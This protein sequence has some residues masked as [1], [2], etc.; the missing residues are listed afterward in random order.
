MGF[1]DDELNEV[2]K[3]CENVVLG[4]RL[5]SCVRSMVRVEIRR[6]RVKSLVVCLQFPEEYPTKTILLELKSKTFSDN[7]LKKITSACEVELKK[8]QGKP[9]ILNVLKFIR[10]FIDE[11]PLICCYDEINKIKKCLT[12]TD[13]LKLKQKSSSLRLKLKEGLYYINSSFDIP[14]NYPEKS[15]QCSI[16]TNFPSILGRFLVG[17]TKEVARRCVE[18]PLI[19]P[20]NTTFTPSPS[21]FPV[22]E[23]QLRAAREFPKSVCL[24]CNKQA[25]PDNPENS[26]TDETDEKHVERIYCG[27]LYHQK[28][29]IDYMKTPPFKGGKKCLGCKERIYHD[30]WKVGE[31]LAEDRWAHHEARMR[32]LDEV[33]DFFK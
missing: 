7:L 10:S 31:K 26:V 28:C 27:H 33:S 21:L 29:L 22:V 24:L 30:K 5:V 11:N 4:S 9:Q 8:W 20:K 19:C 32:E 12:A 25:L 18:P 3:L 16:D 15:V 23:V 14:D 13:E 1:I 17:Q 6:T 2:R